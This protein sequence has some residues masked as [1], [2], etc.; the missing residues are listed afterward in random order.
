MR[1]GARASTLSSRLPQ[2]CLAHGVDSVIV[3]AERERHCRACFFHFSHRQSG[4]AIADIAL[5]HGLEVVEIYRTGIRQPVEMRG[6][7]VVEIT[8]TEMRRTARFC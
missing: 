5:G 4:A 2:R 6:Q 1:A 7:L 3:E 8:T